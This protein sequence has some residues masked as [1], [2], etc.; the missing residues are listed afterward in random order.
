MLDKKRIKE[1]EMNIR[2]YLNEGLLKNIKNIDLKIINME[3]IVMNVSSAGIFYGV[4][5]SSLT[6]QVFP[7]IFIIYFFVF[8]KIRMFSSILKNLNSKAFF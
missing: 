3:L 7:L 1:A 2:S 4:E 8:L 5:K 6:L